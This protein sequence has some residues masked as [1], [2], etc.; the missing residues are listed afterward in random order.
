MEAYQEPLEAPDGTRTLFTA[1]DPFI[2]S[3]LMVF[4]NGLLE[5]FIVNVSSPTFEFETPPLAGDSI[6]LAYGLDA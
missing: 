4:L 3:S 6:M 2:D 5:R 1:P